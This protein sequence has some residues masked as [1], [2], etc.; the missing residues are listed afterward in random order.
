M[1]CRNP[2]PHYRAF[3]LSETGKTAKK[4]DAKVCQHIH[5]LCLSAAKVA[6]L[7]EKR[8]TDLK[9]IVNFFRIGTIE[10]YMEIRLRYLYWIH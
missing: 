9:K 1:F 8:I 7:I 3:F 6:N 4:Q 2:V 10:S 5:R